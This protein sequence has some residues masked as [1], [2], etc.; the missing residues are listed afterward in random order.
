MVLEDK[1]GSIE[2]RLQL[3]NFRPSMFLEILKSRPF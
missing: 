3:F 2:D 1:K